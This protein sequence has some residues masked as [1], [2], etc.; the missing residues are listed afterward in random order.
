MSGPAVPSVSSDAWFDDR[1]HRLVLSEA[2]SN[3]V[4]ESVG[5][6]DGLMKISSRR[7]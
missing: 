4:M 5:T 2:L 3:G 6:N 7:M 1:R